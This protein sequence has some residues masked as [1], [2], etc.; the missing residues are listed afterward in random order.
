MN[1]IFQF[2][3]ANFCSTSPPTSDWHSP[4]SLTKPT[5]RHSLS[6]DIP[7]NFFNVGFSIGQA[8][9]RREMLSLEGTLPGGSVRQ[10]YF[11]H[12]SF[13]HKNHKKKK[14]TNKKPQKKNSWNKIEMKSLVTEVSGRL[15]ISEKYW[16]PY[17]KNRKWFF[18]Y[19]FIVS[20]LRTSLFK[21]DK[22]D[23]WGLV[24]WVLLSFVWV[25]ESVWLDRLVYQPQ[26]SQV[27]TLSSHVRN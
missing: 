4:F 17:E 1:F 16:N 10:F 22:W 18:K 25:S 26:G 2:K 19:C 11:L 6:S 21:W 24:M 5:F 7:T 8:L 15:M 20:S 13:S 3:T 23:K 9:P 12:L 27:T 14:T